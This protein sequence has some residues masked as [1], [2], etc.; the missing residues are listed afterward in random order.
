M[1]YTGGILPAEF[2]TF[3]QA[4]A[5]LGFFAAQALVVALVYKGFVKL[6]GEEKGKKY[7]MVFIL[8]NIPI[9]LILL[10]MF[11]VIF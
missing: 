1:D 8:S 10:F 7:R 2:L 6:F 4:S 11:W 5:L 9:F 3:I